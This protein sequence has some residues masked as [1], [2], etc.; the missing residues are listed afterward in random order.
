MPHDFSLG[1]AVD[2]STED[3]RFVVSGVD[4]DFVSDGLADTAG[5]SVGFSVDC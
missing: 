2:L 4:A 1:C 5:L 3:R